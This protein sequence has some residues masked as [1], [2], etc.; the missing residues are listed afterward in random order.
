MIG[1]SM[2]ALSA[3]ARRL[4]RYELQLGMLALF[5]IGL[6]LGLAVWVAK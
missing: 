2:R 4:A 1:D 6:T 3:R 5:A